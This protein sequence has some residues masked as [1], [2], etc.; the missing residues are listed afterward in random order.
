MG[1]V[2]VA[3][4]QTALDPAVLKRFREDLLERLGSERAPALLLDLSGV[5]LMD[6]EE[7]DW[8]LKLARSTAL[9]G[10]ETWFVGFR[11]EVVATLVLLGAPTDDVRS[12][13]DIDG[14]IRTIYKSR[15]EESG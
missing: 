8:L 12:A 9:M 11:P 7:Y 4:M 5:T 2:L 15:E 14:A 3:T 1:D 10:T 13:L 6:L